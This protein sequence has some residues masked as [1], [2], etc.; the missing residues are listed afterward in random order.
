M[1]RLRKQWRRNA[2]VHSQ[3]F[4]QGQR[5]A[6]GDVIIKHAGIATKPQLT[7]SKPEDETFQERD[8][9]DDDEDTALCPAV[10]DLTRTSLQ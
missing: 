4:G 7:P 1:G 10:S 6:P 2:A 5:P 3:Q 9:G 8:F